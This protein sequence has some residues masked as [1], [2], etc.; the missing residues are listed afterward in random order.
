MHS[1]AL[2]LAVWFS[3]IPLSVAADSLAP[4]ASEDPVLLPTGRLE[5]TLA[6]R[7]RLGGRPPFGDQGRDEWSAP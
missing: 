5:L 3:C 6:G 2:L 1:W 7:G 4:L